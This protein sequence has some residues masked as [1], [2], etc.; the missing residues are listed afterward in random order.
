MAQPQ[1]GV[2]AQIPFGGGLIVDGDA[3]FFHPIQSGQCVHGWLLAWTKREPNAFAPLMQMHGSVQ[4]VAAVV[5]RAA[6]DPNALGMRRPGHGQSGH[7]F[8]SALHQAGMWLGA[9]GMGFH[10][11]CFCH[12]MQR[13]FEQR[14]DSLHVV[15]W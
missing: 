13:P 15:G 5:A 7:G 3:C 1:Q 10:R 2:D 12:A 14:R 9:Q 8:A 4:T 11:P 6:S